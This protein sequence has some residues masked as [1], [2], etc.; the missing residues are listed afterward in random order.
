M[1]VDLLE[2]YA[3]GEHKNLDVVEKLRN[4]LCRPVLILVFGGHP[5]LGRLLDNLL[6]Y[7]VN[8]SI[9]L[10]HGPRTLRASGD[11]LGEVG[12]QR[13]KRCHPFRLPRVR[14]RLRC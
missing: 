12:K 4:L 3:S 11:T 2:G 6:A 5:D 14:V 9:E 10:G 7:G 13:I 8:P 1:G